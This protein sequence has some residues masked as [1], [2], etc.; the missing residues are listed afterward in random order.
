M[1]VDISEILLEC[2]IIQFGRFETSTGNMSPLRFRFELMGTYPTVLEAVV[3][4]LY[5]LATAIAPTV[6]YFVSASDCIPVTSILCGRL[7]KAMVYSRG[8]GA[9]PVHDLMGSYDV[10]HPSCLVVNTITD[11]TKQLLADCNRVGL[12]INHIIELLDTRMTISSIKKQSLYPL[13]D[14]IAVLEKNSLLPTPH[15]QS[16]RDWLDNQKT[17]LQ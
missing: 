10:G 5:P 9:V 1:T 7:A 16:V 8:C 13:L 6:D 12:E 17:A 11:H 3:N 14:I 4:D 15:A 2:G